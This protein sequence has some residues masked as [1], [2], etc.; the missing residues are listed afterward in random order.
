MKL[1]L[2][3]TNDKYELPIYVCDTAKELAE[4]CGVKTNSLYSNIGK[5][6]AGKLASCRYRV[7][8]IEGSEEC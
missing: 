2:K 6:K 7:V 3:V 8:E 1:W 5:Y 4:L